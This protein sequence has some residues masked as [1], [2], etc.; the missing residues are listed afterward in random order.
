M[1]AID[2]QDVVGRFEQDILVPDAALL[3]ASAAGIGVGH[4]SEHVT[5]IGIDHERASVAAE[6]QLTA[7]AGDVPVLPFGVGDEGSLSPTLPLREGNGIGIDRDVVE[8]FVGGHEKFA[9][10]EQQP[11]DRADGL[12]G[13]RRLEAGDGHTAMDERDAVVETGPDVVVGIAKEIEHG[14]VDQSVGHVVMPKQFPVEVEA[15]DAIADG[16]DDKRAIASDDSTVDGSMAQLLVDGGTIGNGV[17][18]SGS[19]QEEGSILGAEQHIAR[20]TELKTCHDATVVIERGM[21]GPHIVVTVEAVVATFDELSPKLSAYQVQVERMLVGDVDGDDAALTVVGGR[22]VTEDGGKGL[23]IDVVALLQDEP[24][25][26]EFHREIADEG[27]KRSINEL[28]EVIAFEV[29]EV[30]VGA[31]IDA[32]A[33]CLDRTDDGIVGYGNRRPSVAVEGEQTLVGG[34]IDGTIVILRAAPYLRTGGES[35]VGG[36]KVGDDG[37]KTCCLQGHNGRQKG[38]KEEVTELHGE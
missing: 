12:M 16:A 18:R 1:L 19:M 25:L 28:T 26:L 5:V 4:R 27:T 37:P 33:H 6:E 22:V 32:V 30:L 9:L 14:V 8:A 3:E 20:S 10:M 15:I 35:V 13:G 38:P 11:E 21:N 2:A 31:Y 29:T 7:D 36:R 17:S 24:G 34:E 23:E